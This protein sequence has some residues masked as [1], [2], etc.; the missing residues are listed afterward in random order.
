[1]PKQAAD[2]TGQG[3]Q[4]GF[5]KSTLDKI[6]HSIFKFTR[7]GLSKLMIGLLFC[8]RLTHQNK[9]IDAQPTGCEMTR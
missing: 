7:F 3:S 4:D 6:C 2:A 1:M 5:K 9:N 8:R